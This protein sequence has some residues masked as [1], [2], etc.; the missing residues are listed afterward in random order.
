MA[1]TS[2]R[3][4]V[5]IQVRHRTG[6]PARDGGGC[7]CRPAYR[8]EVWDRE[9]KRPKKG[10]WLPTQAAARAWR[11][12]AQR[13]AGHVPGTSRTVE[14]ALRDALA[15]AEAGTVRNRSGATFK[16]SVLAS[17]RHVMDARLVPKFGP[18]LLD[19]LTAP[20]L[21]GYVAELLREGLAPSTVRNVLMPLRIAYR[22]AL[23]HGEVQVNPTAGLRLPASATKRDRIADRHEAER[24]LAALPEADR[25]LW[26][27]AL[28][29][30]LRRGELMALRWRNVD[31]GAGVLRVD[32]GR[33]SY[34][35]RSGAFGSPKSRAAVRTVPI[36]ARLRPYLSKP[37]RRDAL[38]FGRADGRPFAYETAV[39][40]A[41]R[42]WAAQDPP[43]TPLGLHEAR[44]TF[45]SYLIASGANAKAVTTAL[46]HG[47]VSITF[48]RYGHLFPGHEDELRG[49][50]DAFLPADD[51]A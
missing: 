9:T 33:G 46:G 51:A 24:L 36:I 15:G 1:T 38:V 25:P 3:S 29:S 10:P 17:Y 13:A 39:A 8:G 5:G 11:V 32:A 12:D 26:A 18:L 34:D 21:Y 27:T 4:A 44:H 2:K 40:R 35:P 43:L 37:G 6:C 7:R 50:L 47:S 16:P 41:R 42:A 19:A 20:V 23:A 48:D 49:L 28:Y 22:E 31:L 30:G 14:E 45:A